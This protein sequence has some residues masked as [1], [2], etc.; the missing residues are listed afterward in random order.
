MATLGLREAFARYGA[1]LANVMYSTSA[2]TPKDTL[3]LSLWSHHAR[4]GPSGT[5]E[6]ADSA[7]R[8]HSKGNSEF[9]LNI[10]RAF[11]SQAEIRLVIAHA[12][13]P[14][15]IEAGEDARKIKKD[16]SVRPELV[17]K[18]I[19]WDGSRYLIRFQTA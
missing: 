17:G 6:F 12:S 18:V 11:E 3:V 10:Q 8:W 1:T 4:R 15:R 16:H 13:D 7:D 2:W 14:A 9:R 5:L 19:E